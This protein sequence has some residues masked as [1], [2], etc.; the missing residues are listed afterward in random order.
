MEKL[1]QDALYGQLRNMMAEEDYDFQAVTFEKNEPEFTCEEGSM[2]QDLACGESQQS[3][4]DEGV[5]LSG[6]LHQQ[7]SHYFAT[8]SSFGARS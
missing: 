1:Q 2:L 3:M 5:S 7:K 6:D 4:I 8:A